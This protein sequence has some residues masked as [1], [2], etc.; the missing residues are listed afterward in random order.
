MLTWEKKRGVN[1]SDLA[2]KSIYINQFLPC[3]L[4]NSFPE[5]CENYGQEGGV[6]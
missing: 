5:R 1:Q 2:L 3:F 6:I 4:G